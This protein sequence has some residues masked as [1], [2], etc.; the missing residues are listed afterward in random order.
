VWLRDPLT[1]GVLSFLLAATPIASA[2]AQAPAQRNVGVVVQ[3]EIRT[4]VE[5][6]LATADMPIAADYYRIDMRFGPNLRIDAV[7]VAA[8]ASDTRVRG[9]RV[10]VRDD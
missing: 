1:F 8:L 10:Q 5:G 3:P 6:L 2:S 4:R 9:V 7:V